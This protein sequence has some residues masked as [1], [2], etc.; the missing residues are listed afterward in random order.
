MICKFD[1]IRSEQGKNVLR[2]LSP[3]GK[4]REKKGGWW[5]GTAL[6]GWKERVKNKRGRR[7]GRRGSKREGARR[8]G[9]RGSKFISMFIPMK[10]PSCQA[11][12]GPS[13]PTDGPTG[14]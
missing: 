5:G 2:Y 10:T 14:V 12:D 9:R 1:K 7:E 11:T 3:L 6:V 4:A 8:E 13:K